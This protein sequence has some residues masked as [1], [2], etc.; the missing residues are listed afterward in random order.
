ML[1]SKQIEKENLK[2]INM[3]NL[4]KIISLMQ[5]LAITNYMIKLKAT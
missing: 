2:E 3:T 5:D 4:I 1:K